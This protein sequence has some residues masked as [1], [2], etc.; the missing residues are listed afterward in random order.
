MLTIKDNY[1][2]NFL[3]GDN[4]YLEKLKKDSNSHVKNFILSN[5]FNSNV[6]VKVTDIDGDYPLAVATIHFYN[7][8]KELEFDIVEQTLHFSNGLD[9][10]DKKLGCDT[11]SFELI[12][13]NSVTI[14][15]LSDGPYGNVFISHT[16][17][18]IIAFFVTHDSMK[19]TELFDKIK[20]ALGLE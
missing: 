5:E 13:V 15:T 18:T 11:A 1:K 14:S 10:T 9:L 2:G 17:E 8:E 19:A 3:I 6:E 20:Y 7:R 16:G 12:G 4:L